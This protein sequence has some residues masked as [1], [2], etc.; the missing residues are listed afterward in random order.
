MLDVTDRNEYI[1][2]ILLMGVSLNSTVAPIVARIVPTNEGERG[3]LVIAQRL[4]Y[5]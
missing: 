5:S 2:N 1:S 4:D 3:L